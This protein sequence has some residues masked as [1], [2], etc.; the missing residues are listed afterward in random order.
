MA[1]TNRFEFRET[2]SGRKLFSTGTAT[3]ITPVVT[4]PNDVNFTGKVVI[5]PDPLCLKSLRVIEG[6]ATT[7]EILDGTANFTE[8]KMPDTVAANTSFTL[9][10]SLGAVNSTIT[11]VLGDGV[12]SMEVNP[13]G[14][15]A[16]GPFTTDNSMVR[17]D[18]VSGTKNIQQSLWVLDDSGDVQL[19]GADYIHTKGTAANQF[20]GIDA[21]TVNTGSNNNG[22][23]NSA[24]TACTSGNSNNAMGRNCMLSLTDGDFNTG[25]GDQCLASLIGGFF[26]CAVGNNA[27]VLTTSGSA[28]VSVGNEAL[29][30]NTTGDNNIAIGRNALK[31][32]ATG[33]SNIGIGFNAGS[34]LTLTDDNNI[35]IENV[36]VV[37]DSG[38]IRIGTFA[39]HGSCFLAGVGGITPAGTPEMVTMDETTGEMGTSGKLVND[40][41]QNLSTSTDNAIARFDLATGKRI[42]NSMLTIDDSGDIDRSGSSYIH[43]RGGVNNQ[44]VG[45]DAFSTAT[46]AVQCT[47]VGCEAL[48]ATD[49][50]NNTAVGFRSMFQS[51]TSENC[52]ATGVIAIG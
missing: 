12:L 52:T 21:G 32:T 3:D 15:V 45:I 22:F 51:T 40:Y 25:M 49:S 42:Q 19:S 36:G 50:N 48:A 39:T 28:N 4:E 24:L 5:N 33:D 47:A 8:L 26:N 16:G 43:T 23:G 18:L 20:L 46:T 17:V 14:F 41:V 44:A 35:C 13:G 30:T 34:A 10:T 6:L 37:A 31:N 38:V 11:D 7:A 1:E 27:L 2:I 29:F 9:P